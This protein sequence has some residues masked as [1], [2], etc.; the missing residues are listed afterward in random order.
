MLERVSVG[1]QA[2]AAVS[3]SSPVLTFETI[4]CTGQ[5]VALEE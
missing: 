4:V 3:G 5:K 1:P 2:E